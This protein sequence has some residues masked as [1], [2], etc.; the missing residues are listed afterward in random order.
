MVCRVLRRVVVETCV[1]C[2]AADRPAPT[3]AAELLEY[4]EN[5]FAMLTLCFL[6]KA[7]CTAHTA[8]P[9]SSDTRYECSS[10]WGSLSKGVRMPPGGQWLEVVVKWP[11]VDGP[12]VRWSPRR[13]DARKDQFVRDNGQATTAAAQLQGPKDQKNKEG[14]TSV[15]D[16][17]WWSSEGG[18]RSRR[19]RSFWRASRRIGSGNSSFHIFRCVAVLRTP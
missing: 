1:D 4:C 16:V 17:G 11:G 13:P 7:G 6:P 2:C 14:Q 19:R 10:R 9:P 8:N 3:A 5:L 15:S 18:L 12:M